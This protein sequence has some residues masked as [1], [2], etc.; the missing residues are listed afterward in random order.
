MNSFFAFYLGSYLGT[1]VVCHTHY[2]IWPFR[3]PAPSFW[4]QERRKYLPADAWLSALIQHAGRTSL[5]FNLP[6]WHHCGQQ[7]HGAASERCVWSFP[8]PP[9]S[10]PGFINE[11]KCKFAVPEVQ[12]LGH[13]VTAEDIG[14]LPKS[15]KAFHIYC[16][17]SHTKIIN[18]GIIFA[19]K[20][21]SNNHWALGLFL[22][23]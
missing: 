4:S 2:S 6:R 20:E 22:K 1:P 16:I 21:S 18:G 14:P 11:E 9:D 7:V 3:V 17:I 15:H 19:Q 13:H 12:F 10:W 8:P 5:S 23:A